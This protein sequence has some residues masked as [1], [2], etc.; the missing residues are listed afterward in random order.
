MHFP[1]NCFI[2]YYSELLHSIYYFTIYY[3]FVEYMI[4][5][6]HPLKG[7]KMVWVL[8]SL[9]FIFHSLHNDLTWNWQWH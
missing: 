9:I 7:R 5:A 8:S 4:R 3:P 1:H 2:K 6:K